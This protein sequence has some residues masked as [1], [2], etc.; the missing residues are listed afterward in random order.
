MSSVF[1][2][3]MQRNMDEDAALTIQR[4]RQSLQEDR[5]PEEEF[6]EIEQEDIQE[7]MTPEQEFMAIE[8]EDMIIETEQLQEDTDETFFFDGLLEA[9][10][11]KI[12]KE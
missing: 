11:R 6:M 10:K 8:Q 2:N 4:S 5:T 12:K 9:L 7:N 3:E 1:L